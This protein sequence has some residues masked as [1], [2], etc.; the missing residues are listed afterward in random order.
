MRAPRPR[1]PIAASQLADGSRRVEVALIEQQRLLRSAAER[2]GTAGSTDI[3]HG[4]VAARRLRSLLKTYGPLLDER[5]TRLMRADLRSFARTLSAVREAD[6]RRDL[7]TSLVRNEP[8]VAPSSLK[9]LMIR[10]ED[11]CLEARASLRRH[12][13]EPHWT[14]LRAA[15]EDEA[16]MRGLVVR[17]DAGLDDLLELV[18]E[19]W[20]KAVRLLEQEPK[21]AAEL[22]ELRLALKHCRYALESVA[23]VQPKA[24]ARLLRRL[25]GAQDSIGEHRDTLL[26]DHWVRLNERSLGRPLTG[27]LLEL[28]KQHERRTRK[29]AAGRAAKVLAAYGDWRAAIRRVRKGTRTG[30]A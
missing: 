10:L 25:R 12:A 9:R 3:H 6:V 22:H 16:A 23:D 14:A 17:R 19:S 5:R 2:L 4:R 20:R 8:G 24:V 1:K 30:R 21:E 28:L 27:R 15:V 11:L 18:E 7:L 29:R 13:A 26:A